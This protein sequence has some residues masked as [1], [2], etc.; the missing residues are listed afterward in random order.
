MHSTPLAGLH[1]GSSTK[2]CG[3]RN[4]PPSSKEN[5]FMTHFYRCFHNVL[6]KKVTPWECLT[7]K[8]SFTTIGSSRCSSYFSKQDLPSR[9]QCLGMASRRPQFNKAINYAPSFSS[10]SLNV[11]ATY[12]NFWNSPCLFHG[13]TI[14]LILKQTVYLSFTCETMSNANKDTMRKENHFVSDQKVFLKQVI[15]RHS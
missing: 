10:Y 2:T 15:L 8:K 13:I 6:M 12:W 4:N 7:L 3:H 11:E 5:L 9:A 14:K 1:S